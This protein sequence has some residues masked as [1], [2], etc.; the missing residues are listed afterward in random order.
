LGKLDGKVAIIT[1]AG[2]G[3][4]KAT[5]LLFTNEGAKV[6][7]A[8]NAISSGEETLSMI[9]R[10]GGEALFIKTDVSLEDDIKKMIEAAVDNYGK[11]DILFNNAGIADTLASTHEVNVSEWHRIININL[12][13]VFLGMKYAIPEMLKIGGGAIINASSLAGLVGVPR[14]ATYCASKGGVIQLTKAAAL[15]YAAKNIRVNC[16][17]P[18]FIWTPMQETAMRHESTVDSKTLEE[19]KMQAISL[20]P[21]GRFGKP[22][23]VAR[24]AVFLASDDASFITGVALPVDGGYTAQ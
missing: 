23:E 19:I 17:C 24:A 11:L 18:G 1:G 16:I 4:G 22:E 2:A 12:N 5:A 9:K 14:R 8:D 13:G 15:E 6:V 10:D 20:S 21:I 7:V 3:I